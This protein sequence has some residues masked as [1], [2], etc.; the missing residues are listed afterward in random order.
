[1]TSPERYR[2]D[3]KTGKLILESKTARMV[4]KA[5]ERKDAR[6]KQ[7]A[8]EEARITEIAEME[9][10][11]DQL[12]AKLDALVGESNKKEG[13]ANSKKRKASE[14][15]PSASGSVEGRQGPRGKGKKESKAKEDEKTRKVY[16][17]PLLD[18]VVS[19]HVNSHCHRHIDLVRGRTASS[20]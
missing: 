13:K 12:V 3:D 9:V 20:T 19:I 18:V 4:R 1:M 14:T 17:C 16:I 15:P 5:A 7:T 6:A 2:R 10:A 8:K 11:R